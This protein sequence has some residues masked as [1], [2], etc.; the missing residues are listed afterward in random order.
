MYTSKNPIES[1]NRPLV[2]ATIRT[3]TARRTIALIFAASLAAC[4]AGGSGSV[5]PAN[6]LVGEWGITALEGSPGPVDSTN[7]IWSFHADGTYDWLFFFPGFFN[8]A[9]SGTYAFEPGARSIRLTGIVS[10]LLLFGTPDPSHLQLTS[11]SEDRFTFDDDEGDQWRYCRLTPPQTTGTPVISHLPRDN[12]ICYGSGELAVDFKLEDREELVA[13]RWWGGYA[14]NALSSSNRFHVRFYEADRAGGPGGQPIATYLN[15]EASR[16][17]TL[18]RAFAALDIFQFDVVLPQPF[19]ARATTSYYVSLEPATAPSPCWYDSMRAGEFWIHSQDVWFPSQVAQLAIELLATPKQG[20]SALVF[21]GVDDRVDFGFVT[22]VGPHTIEAW[23]KPGDDSRL[24]VAVGQLA[25][26][27]QACTAGM[28]LGI[29][30]T[31][32]ESF[33][34]YVLEPAG[35]GNAIPL[36]DPTVVPGEW[37]HLAG[38]FDGSVARF[39]VDGV[40]AAEREGARFDASDY[41]SAGAVVFFNG[42]QAHFEG[43]LDEVRI[44]DRARTEQEIRQS[45]GKRLRGTEAGLVGYWDFDEGNGQVVEDRSGSGTVG[46]LGSGFGADP[47]DPVWVNSGAPV[48]R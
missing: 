47:C 9:G 36:I 4:G 11:S 34:T 26:P 2:N 37:V 42:T 35:C 20:G 7:S 1:T 3:F 44:W 17:P 30:Q 45:M 14:N 43:A 18:I 39:F 38:T 22:P 48:S 15:V 24:Q 32:G 19:L 29:G 27:G 6:Y 16:S 21:D 8:E 31:G 13:V 12:G 46:V 10:D 41:M 25:G 5:L 23:I 28:Y 40:L 33:T